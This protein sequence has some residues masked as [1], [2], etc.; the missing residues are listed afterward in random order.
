V[1]PAGGALLPET[2]T[3]SRTRPRSRSPLY[4]P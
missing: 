1:V 3:V 4:A 2:L